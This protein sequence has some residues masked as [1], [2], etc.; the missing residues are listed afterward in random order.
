MTS[1]ENIVIYGIN[2]APEIAGVGRYS[3]E[4]GAHLAAEGHRVCVV[5]APPHY[6]GWRVQKPHR[7]GWAREVLAGAD[8][9]RCPLYLSEQM[10]GVRRLLAPL[11]FA[12]SSAPVALWTIL[13]RRPSVVL[14]VE[15][16]L[17]VAPV[18]LLAARL[19]GARTV[20]HVQDLEVE[21]AFAV[22]HL[23]RGGLLARVAGAYDRAMV[24]RFSRIVTISNRMAEKIIDKGADASKVAIVRNWVDLDQVRPDQD[25]GAYRRELGISAGTYVAL[26]SGNLG[27]KQGVRL[28]WEAAEHLRDRPG[29]LF[30]VAG[31]GPMR[32]ELAQAAA[33]LPNLRLLDFQP[34]HRFGEFLSM[35]DVHLLPQEREAADLLLP[36]KLGGMLASA[37]PIIVTADPDTELADF[38]GT[39]CKLTP[40][41]DSA[42]LAASVSQAAESDP[43]P[44]LRAERLTLAG[45]LAKTSGIA[46]FVKAALFL[47]RADA[48]SDARPIA[49]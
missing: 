6:P 49:A 10:K 13:R 36:S 30:L 17:F 48:P 32:S 11:S 37:K 15:P 9:Y 19:V 34:E 2:Y 1:S 29:I 8:L 41:G 12:A 3:G 44:V 35:A 42:A 38:L 26:Y 40:P 27:A 25:A 14:V 24:R 28:I 43:D 46:Q 33:R 7:N 23:G 4:I 22:G 5:T 39:S 16:T 18:A 47:Q 45:Q 20:L 21:A 31:D